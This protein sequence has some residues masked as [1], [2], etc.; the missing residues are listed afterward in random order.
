MFER[1]IEVI[2]VR[3][4]AGEQDERVDFDV[5]RQ[6]LQCPDNDAGPAGMGGEGDPGAG[7]G[8]VDVD[9]TSGEQAGLAFVV[10]ELSECEQAAVLAGPVDDRWTSR[11]RS[12]DSES[13][14]ARAARGRWAGRRERCRARR[15]S[16]WSRPARSEKSKALP[17][18]WG[19]SS[20][21][22]AIRIKTVPG[23]STTVTSSH[24]R[25]H[26]RASSW[27]GK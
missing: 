4:G 18:A 15:R 14:P 6:C 27:V 25:P 24:C 20:P 7:V 22:K 16:R 10:I 23:Y 19:T 8:A 2:P 3:Q 12:P 17:I 11:R 5:L 21:V 13:T 1:R 9:D 26:W